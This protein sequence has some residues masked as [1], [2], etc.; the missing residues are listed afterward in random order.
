MIVV[1]YCLHEYRVRVRVPKV[2]LKYE[3]CMSTV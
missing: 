2:V 1:E 3:Y